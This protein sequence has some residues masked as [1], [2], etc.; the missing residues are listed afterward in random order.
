MLGM[1]M[2]TESNT[3]WG[4][5]SRIWTTWRSELHQDIHAIV[6]PT[7]IWLVLSIMAVK[8]MHLQ[9]VNIKMTFLLENLEK[10][11]YMKWAKGFQITKKENLI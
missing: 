3:M 11:F 4:S 7:I 8:N 5:L 10:E 1:K 2:M 6:K 9:K